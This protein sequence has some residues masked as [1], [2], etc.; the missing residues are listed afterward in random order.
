MAHSG[1]ASRSDWEITTEHSQELRQYLASHTHQPASQSIEKLLIINICG[2]EHIQ[3]RQPYR[4][5]HVHRHTYIVRI[6]IKVLSRK[7]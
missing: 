5:K 4:H 3:R 1:F 6:L 2:Y 7:V